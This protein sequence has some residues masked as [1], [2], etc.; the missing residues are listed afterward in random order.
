MI[1]Y[2]KPDVIAEE[3]SPKQPKLATHN[4]QTNSKH[5]EK[6]NI[7]QQSQCSKSNRI[8]ERREKI[9]E[10]QIEQNI[11]DRH[12][13]KL[14]FSASNMTGK[15]KHEKI[16]EKMIAEYELEKAIPSSRPNKQTRL[17]AIKHLNHATSEHKH[18]QQS[19]SAAIHSRFINK[20]ESNCRFYLST[21]NTN[22]PNFDLQ[23]PTRQKVFP[24][25]KQRPNQST[26]EYF[27]EGHSRGLLS[28]RQGMIPLMHVF[29][30]SCDEVDN[31]INIAS[32]T[33]TPDD[34]SAS[35]YEFTEKSSAYKET[36]VS[37]GST[38]HGYSSLNSALNLTSPITQST[39][40]SPSPFISSNGS[41]ASSSMSS[42]KPI[43]NYRKPRQ[44][45]GFN[46]QQPHI[47]STKY[48]NRFQLYT[49]PNANVTSINT[50]KITPL[51]DHSLIQATTKLTS[52]KLPQKL[53]VF[54]DSSPE[55]KQEL[56]D[57]LQQK[58]AQIATENKQRTGY[59][60]AQSRKQ[61][62]HHNSNSFLYSSLLHADNEDD[63]YKSLTQ[64][65]PDR[66][67]QTQSHNLPNTQPKTNAMP[68]KRTFAAV[69]RPANIYVNGI[70]YEKL[71]WIGK[72][73]SGKVSKVLSPDRQIFALKEVDLAGH[74]DA[75]RD[76]FLNEKNLLLKLQGQ[77]R[78]IKLIDAELET[79]TMTLKMIME[80]GEVDLAQLLQD[81]K[82]SRSTE[83]PRYP[84][85]DE[86]HLR[87]YVQQMLEALTCIHKHNIVHGDLKPANFLSV[88]G[89]LKLIDFGIAS[90]IEVY[91]T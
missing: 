48:E 26:S 64:K 84:C 1:S 66:R 68:A 54:K 32:E 47:S 90:G 7:E 16:S 53:L 21:E 69:Q 29:D 14:P 39:P 76:S 38:G 35:K 40:L 25:L 17:R 31:E 55:E 59:S 42:Y 45:S 10:K 52:A 23:I 67:N 91:T 22:S 72:G 43:T 63:K 71:S 36:N 61:H 77:P 65:L 80:C 46:I 12:Q 41:S 13:G 62:E 24:Q 11:D 83:V 73:G 5:L 3:S 51:E 56:Q 33:S 30:D 20:H 2:F 70:S 8:N 85:I 49:E 75:T 58:G 87:L 15:R 81:F 34:E 9:Q 6:R 88:K 86:N 37:M 60:N 50:E 89:N 74:D 79:E 4:Q 57:F 78:I 44:R 19:E 82:I 28:H 27:L 18:E